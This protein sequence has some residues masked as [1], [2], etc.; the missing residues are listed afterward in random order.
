MSV[1]AHTVPV[2][3]WVGEHRRRREA[4]F[5]FDFLAGY[6]GTSGSESEIEVMSRIMRGAES[7]WLHTI[8]DADVLP[9][10]SEVFAA[11]DWHERELAE[12]YGVTIT[13]RVDCPPL[14]GAQRGVMRKSV[15]LQ[16]RLNL[17]WPGAAELDGRQGANPSRRRLRPPGVPDGASHG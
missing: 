6:S 2:R 15:H 3:D 5:T 9:S 13:G 12:M 4:G 8:V 7:V 16:P 10:I 1:V 14:L 11:A 17:P